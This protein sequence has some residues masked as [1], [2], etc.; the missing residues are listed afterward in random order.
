MSL[1]LWINICYLK[2]RDVIVVNDVL[3]VLWMGYNSLNFNFL[4]VI[5][6]RVTTRNAQLNC[7]AIDVVQR[8]ADV[9]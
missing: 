5:C 8:T 4:S 9:I 6:V 1:L 7:P 3:I 2:Q